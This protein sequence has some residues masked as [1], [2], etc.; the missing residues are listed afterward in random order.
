[1]AETLLSPSNVLLFGRVLE[2]IAIVKKPGDRHNPFTQPRKGT[3]SQIELQ[4]LSDDSRFAR[5]YAFSYEGVFYELPRPV[6]F[7]VHGPGVDAS[8]GS[9]GGEAGGDGPR[10]PNRARAPG[11]PSLIGTSA[12]DFQHADDVKVW[13]YDQADYTIRMDMDIGMFEQVLLDAVIG[14]SPGTDVSGMNARGMNARG[15]N[16]RGMNARGMNARGMNARGGNSD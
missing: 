5:I 9:K 3:P 15:M 4:L 1:M 12:A 7:L 14:G 2:D 10:D 13:S 16:A 6:V 11:N 8:E